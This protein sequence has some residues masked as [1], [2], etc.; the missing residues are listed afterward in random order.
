MP[1]HVH[2]LIDLGRESSLA[3]VLREIKS[4]SSAWLNSRMDNNSVGKADMVNLA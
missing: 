4:K 2:L 1:D 3:T